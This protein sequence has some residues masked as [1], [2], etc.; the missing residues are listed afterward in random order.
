MQAKIIYC[1]TS[2]LPQC[3]PK[4][5]NSPPKNCARTALAAVCKC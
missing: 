1:T 2:V 4:E 5:K 3:R